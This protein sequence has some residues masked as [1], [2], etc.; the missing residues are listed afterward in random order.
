MTLRL[1]AESKCHFDSVAFL[2]SL[3][4]IEELDWEAE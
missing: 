2:I 1:R 4:M 3:A